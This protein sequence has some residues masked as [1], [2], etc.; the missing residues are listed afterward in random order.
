VFVRVVQTSARS[1]H[2]EGALAD[3]AVTSGGT[4]CATRR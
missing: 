1:A 2:I 4:D 3:R